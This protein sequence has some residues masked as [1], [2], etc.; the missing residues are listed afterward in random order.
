MRRRQIEGVMPEA[1]RTADAMA[2]ACFII[3]DHRKFADGWDCAGKAE[4]A[5]RD[6]KA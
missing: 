1:H 6:H 5:G 2:K 4:F 3:E